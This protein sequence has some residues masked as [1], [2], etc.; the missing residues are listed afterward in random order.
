[1]INADGFPQ[2][3]EEWVVRMDAGKWTD[4]DECALADWLAG[5]VRRRGELLDA[6][7][8][9]MLLSETFDWPEAAWE[10][11]GSIRRAAYPR[12]AILAGGSAVLAASLAGGFYLLGK[13]KRYVTDFGEVRRVS[14]SDG[15]NAVINSGSQVSVELAAARRDVILSKGE[16]W[17]RVAKDPRRPFI[18]QAGELRVRAIGTAFSVKK[19]G[20]GADV[21]VTEGKVESWI[22]DSDMRPVSLSAGERAAFTGRSGLTVETDD[23]SAIDRKLAWRDGMIDLIGIPIAEAIEDFNRYNERKIILRETEIG[24]ERLDG[25]FRTDDPEGFARLVGESFNLPVR[26]NGPMNIEIGNA[27]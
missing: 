13:G 21:L 26:T 27:P 10:D 19:R 1:M 20:D 16:A 8:S 23:L 25:M 15:S 18:V 14:L 12:R 24:K 5:D 2:S 7:A 4:A 17:F 22:A 3:A 11:K 9:W 6:Q